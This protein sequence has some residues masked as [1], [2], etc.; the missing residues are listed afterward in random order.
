MACQRQL[1]DLERQERTVRNRTPKRSCH[2]A[3]NRA[4]RYAVRK[5]AAG[6]V[7][8]RPPSFGSLV[9]LLDLSNLQQRRVSVQRRQ[10]V[11]F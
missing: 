2:E 11:R 10:E 1:F 8:N 4:V 6:I 3:I 7:I 5:R 9:R